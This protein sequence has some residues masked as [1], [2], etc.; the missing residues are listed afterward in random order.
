MCDNIFCAVISCS[1]CYSAIQQETCLQQQKACWTPR[2]FGIYCSKTVQS[3]GKIENR[4]LLGSKGTEFNPI[5]I[6]RT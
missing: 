1:P 3:N 2:G 5:N 6:L 4:Q